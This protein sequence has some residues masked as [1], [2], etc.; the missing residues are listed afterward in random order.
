MCVDFTNCELQSGNLVVAVNPD[1]Y[2]NSGKRYLVSGCVINV[3]PTGANIE[4][5]DPI[6]GETKTSF[7]KS[8]QLFG[9]KRVK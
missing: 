7:R 2:A 6:T 1:S 3:T 9:V 4:Y 5:T 8:S